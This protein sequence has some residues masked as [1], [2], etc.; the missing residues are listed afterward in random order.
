[1]SLLAY[2][3][4]L[5]LLPLA[6]FV[7]VIATG[8][9]LPQNGWPRASASR[10]W[11]S[12]FAASLRPA[13]VAIDQRRGTSRRSCRGSRSG[14]CVVEL[15]VQ[16][17]PLTA[18][19]LVVVSL[20]SLLVQIYSIGYMGDD[21]RFRWYFGAISLFTAAM[22]GVV[23]ANGWL[24]M[25]MCWEVMGLVVVPAHRLLVRGA[26]RGARRPARR[27]SSRAS[28][29]SASG[30]R[31]CS[32]G[33]A[34]AAF[35]FEEV[36]HLVETGQLGR[37]DARRR[38]AAAVHGRDGQERAVPAARVAPRRDGRP[39]AGLGAHPRRDDG[40][41]RRL[42]GRAL[43]S[44]CSRRIPADAARWSRSSARSPRCWPRSSR[45]R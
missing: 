26:D 1:M 24:L 45:S 28:A 8:R 12:V 6:V 11:A 19:M 5:P 14:R 36:F 17:D 31:S 18:L 29:T 3:W 16:I 34:G 30:S 10:R 40:R 27:S 20:V 38:R 37:P 21:E 25:Y 33:L 23:L 13:L 4:V 9:R 43:V 35:Q 32:C 42:P 39:D 44:R 22:L 41:R 7:V 15:G 2:S